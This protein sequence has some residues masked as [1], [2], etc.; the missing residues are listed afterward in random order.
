MAEV[1]R[2]RLGE[3]Q[4]AIFQALLDKPDGLPVKEVTRRA[5]VLCPATPFENEDYPNQPGVRR[6]PKMQR[7]ATITSVKAG[8]LVKNKG[9]WRLTE[10]GRE[11]YAEHEDSAE[12]QRAAVQ[13][14]R[15]WQ[16]ERIA[17]SYD[18]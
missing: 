12:F 11:A 16:A 5:E 1:S 9:I 15:D 3:I 8:W 13:G 10:Q 4:R 18:A 14:Y 6:Y 7:F 2:E 17:E